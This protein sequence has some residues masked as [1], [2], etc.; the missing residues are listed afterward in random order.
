[1]LTDAAIRAAKP[2]EHAYEVT[3]GGC[4]GLKLRITPKGQKSWTL[5]YRTPAGDRRRYTLARYPALKLKAARAKGLEVQASIAQGVDPN[6]ARARERDALRMV[7][8]F[9]NAGD[10]GW[11]LSTYVKTGTFA[12]DAR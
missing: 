12:T 11:F 5:R 7:D 10:E 3:A 1:M 8:L 9:G 4:P 2:R 6:D